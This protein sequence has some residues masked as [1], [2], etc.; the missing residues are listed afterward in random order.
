MSNTYGLLGTL[1]LW[2]GVVIG[3]AFLAAATRLRRYRDEG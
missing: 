1:N 3:L 2:I